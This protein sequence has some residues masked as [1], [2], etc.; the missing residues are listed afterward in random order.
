[1][2]KQLR[3]HCT[4]YPEMIIQWLMQ[5]ERRRFLYNAVNSDLFLMQTSKISISL[6]Y[7]K[8]FVI[9]IRKQVVDKKAN[10]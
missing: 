4:E 3:K 2:K 1:M 6:A 8:V 9:K 10:G 5:S 7:G